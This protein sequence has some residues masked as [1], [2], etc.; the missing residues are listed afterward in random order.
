MR[1]FEDFRL[2]FAGPNDVCN[3]IDLN[4]RKKIIKLAEKLVVFSQNI[5]V[6]IATSDLVN[7]MLSYYFKTK[8][9]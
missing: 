8:P 6:S 5:P 3:T 7:T 9:W 1:L 4:A 2:K